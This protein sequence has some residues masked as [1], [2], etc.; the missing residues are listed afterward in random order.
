MCARANAQ[1]SHGGAKCV[2]IHSPVG[3]THHAVH[4]HNVN[5]TRARGIVHCKIIWCPHVYLWHKQSIQYTDHDSSS[6]VTARPCAPPEQS[7]YFPHNTLPHF[8]LDLPFALRFHETA[9]T[10]TA[11]KHLCAA[12]ASSLHLPVEEAAGNARVE[13]LVG[14]A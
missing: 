11:L 12:C 7:T 6:I 8:T 10:K 2:A 13:V 4:D 3:C 5:T 1:N 9:M 14:G